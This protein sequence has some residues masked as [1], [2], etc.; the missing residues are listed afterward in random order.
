MSTPPYPLHPEPLKRSW[1][2]CHPLWK[3]PLGFATLM[4]LIC[5]FAVGAGTIVVA[6]Y[7]HSDVY[8]QAMAKALGNPTVREQMGEPIQAAWFISGSLHINGSSGN[9][10]FS[11]PISGPR[12]NGSIRVIAFKNAGVWRFTYLQVNVAGRGTCIDLLADDIGEQ[13]TADPR[14]SNRHTPRG[15]AAW[16]LQFP[17]TTQVK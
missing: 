11:I 12:A 13:D 16:T 6:S 8:K 17:F 9:A 15:G 10:D 14:W 7:R 5:G 2:E 1:I 4:L 3:I